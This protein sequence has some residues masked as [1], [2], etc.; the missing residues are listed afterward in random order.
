MIARS[1]GVT[2]VVCA[3]N[4]LDIAEWREERY[5]Q[6][7]QT[8]LPFLKTIG[9]KENNVQFVP[10]SGLQGT[11]LNSNKFNPKELIQWYN[12]ESKEAFKQGN[13]LTDCI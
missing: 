9:F 12:A 11:N 4:K 3:V 2:Q 1:L 8:V 6:I 7:C 10:I 13:C 5:D